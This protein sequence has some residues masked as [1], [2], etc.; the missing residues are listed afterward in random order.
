MNHILATIAVLACVLP[1]QR[2]RRYA[3]TANIKHLKLQSAMLTAHWGRPIHLD[4]GVVLPPDHQLSRR[5]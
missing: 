3:D 1:A 4:A 2:E 5:R